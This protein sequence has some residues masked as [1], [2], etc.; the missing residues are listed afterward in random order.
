MCVLPICLC[1]TYMCVWTTY[2]CALPIC[3]CA[4]Y[5]CVCYLYVCVTYMHVCYLY[6]CVL[7]I[8]VCYLYVCVTYMCVLPRYVNKDTKNGTLTGKVVREIFTKNKTKSSCWKILLNGMRARHTNLHKFLFCGHIS[9][10]LWVL[11]NFA[12]TYVEEIRL[13]RRR[14]VWNVFTFNVKLRMTLINWN[15]LFQ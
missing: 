9:K 14:D 13:L 8:C 2:M 12:L 7:P 3:M 4:T 15:R 1:S 5:I 11:S 6:V 10:F